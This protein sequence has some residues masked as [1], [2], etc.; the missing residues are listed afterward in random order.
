MSAVK[1]FID[2]NTRRLKIDEFLGMELNSAGYGGVEIRKMPTRTEVVIH[3]SRPGVVIGRRGSKIRELT[4]ILEHDFGVRNVQVE[5]AEIE[6]PWLNAQVM[7]SRLARQLERGVRFRRMAYWILRRVMRA[8]AL[9][10]EII[11][12]GKLSS[13]RARYQKFRQATIAKTGR[14]AEL[15]VDEADD[16]AVLKPGVIGVKVRIMKPDAKLPGVITVKK[17]KVKK[18]KERE[19]IKAPEEVKAEEAV[20]EEAEVV[21]SELEGI[22]DIEELKELEELDALDL[23]ED[24]TPE[25]PASDE[26]KPEPAPSEEEAPSESSPPEEVADVDLSELDEL[27]KT[28][29]D[30]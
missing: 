3:A 27:D 11:V 9:G 25:P 29:G 21:E 26:S 4:D 12:K 22:T 6:N 17:P 10:C 16:I 2:Q 14:P 24:V 19:L 13:R 7:A 5:V 18:V 30:E 20:A 1:Y 8:G 23:V 15:F 28:E